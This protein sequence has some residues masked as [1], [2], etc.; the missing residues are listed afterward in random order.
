M[1]K[2]INETI[3]NNLQTLTKNLKK[4]RNKKRV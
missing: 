4:N 2:K 3:I 1:K